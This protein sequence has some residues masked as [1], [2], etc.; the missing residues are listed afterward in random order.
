MLVCN[1]LPPLPKIPLNFSPHF[2]KNQT[3]YLAT[4]LVYGYSVL[5]EVVSLAPNQR[6]VVVPGGNA[7]LSF[8]ITNAIPMVQT[9]DIRWYYAVNTPSGSQDFTSENFQDITELVN[10]TSVSTLDLNSDRLTLD[11]SNIVQAIGNV[12]ETDQGRYFLSATNPAG[13]RN[14]YIDVIVTGILLLANLV[15]C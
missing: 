11:I 12:M 3:N 9:S 4:S 7:T 6:V 10:R 15:V 5:P 1:H 8:N 2:P 14:N 13:E